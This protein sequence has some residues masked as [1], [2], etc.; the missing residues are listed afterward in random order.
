M[1]SVSLFLGFK[2]I[3]STREVN[4]SKEKEAL[5]EKKDSKE[6]NSTVMNESII[7]RSSSYHQ[8]DQIAASNVNSVIEAD[9]DHRASSLPENIMPNINVCTDSGNTDTLRSHINDEEE[10]HDLASFLIHR[11]CKNF[12]LANDFYWYLICER[13]EL[14]Q[15]NIVSNINTV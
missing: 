7:H 8:A 1:L 6:S 11:A 10:I 12:T 5:L 3:S 4:F 14:D 9:A 15:K 2:R 13:G